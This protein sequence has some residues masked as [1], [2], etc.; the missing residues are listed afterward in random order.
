MR[1]LFHSELSEKKQKRNGSGAGKKSKSS[2]KSKSRY[3]A[4]SLVV[5]Y[6]SFFLRVKTEIS[7]IKRKR[8]GPD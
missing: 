5:E 6:K 8:E 1:E 4:A 2:F 3:E 7:L